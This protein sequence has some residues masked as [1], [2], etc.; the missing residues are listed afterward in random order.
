M[1][2]G[3]TMKK[4]AVMFLAFVALS[5]QSLPAIANEY[6]YSCYCASGPKKCNQ[7]ESLSILLK[8]SKELEAKVTCDDWD[9]DEYRLEAR[10]SRYRSSKPYALKHTVFVISSD[11]SDLPAPYRAGNLLIENEMKTGGK[12]TPDAPNYGKA[13]VISSK[14]NIQLQYFC[15]AMKPK[16]F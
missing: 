12:A 5:F 10:A 1:L 4:V 11:R 9:C 6:V 15:K 8:T 16:Y 13:Y 3:V 14:K 2:L 7:M